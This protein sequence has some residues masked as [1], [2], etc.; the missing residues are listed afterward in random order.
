MLHFAYNL[1]QRSQKIYFVGTA[2]LGE[3]HHIN[4]SPKG[5]S[6]TLNLLDSSTSWYLDLTGSGN[7]TIAHLNE[8]GRITI[9]FVAFEGPPKIVRLFGTGQSFT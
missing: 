7:E 4:I 6:T 2:P 3:H 5:Y 1:R 8:N 9:L